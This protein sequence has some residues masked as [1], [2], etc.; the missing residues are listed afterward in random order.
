[1][2]GR[3]ALFSNVTEILAHADAL[4]ENTN[5]APRYNIS[6][7]TLTLGIRNTGNRKE[8]S[9]LK[10][11]YTTPKSTSGTENKQIFIINTR[12]ETIESKKSFKLEQRCLIPANGFYE[13]Q[14]ETKQPYYFSL[15]D[16]ELFFF[17]ATCNYFPQATPEEEMNRFSII[18]TAA[19]DLVAPVHHRMPVIISVSDI[20]LWFNEPDIKAI[21]EQMSPYPANKMKAIPVSNR[22]N[23]AKNDDSSLIELYKIGGGQ[24][25]IEF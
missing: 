24:T 3:F 8:L 5:W 9:L 19:N 23:V 20:D 10:W 18:T 1:M 25:L 14:R 11:G 2:C 13:W 17:G 6:P 7:G 16:E 15:I 22:V 12:M 4:A 21:L